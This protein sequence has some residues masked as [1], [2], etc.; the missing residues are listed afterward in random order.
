MSTAG[1]G[2]TTDVKYIFIF[3]VDR[4]HCPLN[5]LDD[6]SCLAHNFHVTA[7]AGWAIQLLK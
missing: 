1:L 7:V 5:S 3:V 2:A 6:V 4:Y